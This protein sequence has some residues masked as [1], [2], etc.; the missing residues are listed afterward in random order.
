MAVLSASVEIGG[1]G[2]SANGNASWV[3]SSSPTAVSV[4][5]TSV[6]SIGSSM[7]ST[8]TLWL[9]R[10]FAWWVNAAGAGSA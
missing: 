5:S 9:A 8:L 3:A 6:G 10:P 1:G 4:I 2:V 7:A